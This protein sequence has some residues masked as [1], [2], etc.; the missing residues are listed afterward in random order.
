MV[1]AMP[2]GAGR[3]VER[4]AEV[5]R[6]SGM[7]IVAMTGLHTSRFYPD[8]AWAIDGTPEEWSALFIADIEEG[9][10][11]TDHRAGII[12]VATSGGDLSDRDVRLIEA[13]TAA[14]RATGAPILTHCENGEGGMEQVAC[15]TELGMPPH[16]VM[17]SHT[18]KVTDRG[19]HRDLLATGVN[20]EY[21]QSLRL[22]PTEDN[23]TA[24]LLAEMVEAGYVDQL[25]LGTD[26]ARRSLWASLEGTPGLAWLATGFLDL[27]QGF[28]ITDD[29]IRALF[30]T[31]PQRLLAL[32]EAV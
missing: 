5:S 29:D 27:I 20:L 2:I 23:G 32:E 17:L 11:R 8:Q 6:R 1:D 4:L 24:R 16:R 3:S 10:D 13:A 12:K 14:A 31:N 25:M 26:G 9:I 19:Y 28:G 7:P 15:F 21:D 18:D 22:P 30:E